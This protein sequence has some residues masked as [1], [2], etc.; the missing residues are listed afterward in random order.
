[1]AKRM[2]IF[3]V[4]I[5]FLAGLV[6]A[7]T[8]S[9]NSAQKTITIA[10]AESK[11][12]TEQQPDVDSLFAGALMAAEQ[13]NKVG[14]IN[15]SAVHVVPYADANDPLIAKKNAQLI[16][17]SDALAVIGHSSAETTS[18]A[19]PIY[20][21]AQMSAL[22]AS[23]M[24]KDTI[25]NFPDYFNISYTSEQQGAYLANYAIK[26]LKRN[27]T[28]IIV[29]ESD[30]SN[31]L[32]AT[33]FENTFRGLGGTV[34]LLYKN[35]QAPG[36]QLRDAELVSI[37]G[38]I[39]AAQDS[40]END[41]LLISSNPSTSAA[42]VIEL[43]NHG[44]N[45]PILGG[46]NLS[47]QTFSNQIK[48]QK[49]EDA[50]PGYFTD[51][52][53]TTRALFQDNV[54]QFS[55]QFVS[56]Y[57]D[58]F[59]VEG[60]SNS[61]AHGYD[62][63][64]TIFHAIQ[65]SLP[66]L[67]RASVAKGIHKMT[68]SNAPFYGVT[69]PLYFDHERMAGLRQPLLGMYQ[70]GYL[71]SAPI[72]FH[73]AISENIPDLDRQ[74]K[75]GHIIVMDGYYV[76][77]T[78]I[79]YTGM[80]IIE[81]SNLDQKTST[82]TADFYLWFRYLP[83]ETD[84]DFLPENYT[85]TNAES[86][87]DPKIVSS[88][89]TNDGSVYKT[90]RISGQF[91][92]EFQ[93][94]AYPFDRQDLPIQFR[95]Q[96]AE[97]SLIEYVIDRPGMPSLSGAGLSTD[98]KTGQT[99]Q[100]VDGWMTTRIEADQSI[101][102][103]SSTLGNPFNFNKA[104]AT[105][106]SIFGF[107]ILLQ[108]NSLAIVI[109]SLLPLLITLI[110][111]YI[112]FFLPVGN[113]ERL[114]VAS[115]ALLTVAFFHLSFSE[116]LPAIGYTVAME[117]FFYAGYAVSAAIVFLETW[118]MRIEKKET[119]E[120]DEIKKAKYQK[121]RHSL[122]VAGRIIYPSV[123]LSV[124]AVGMFCFLGWID[125]NPK[126]ARDVSAMGKFMPYQQSLSNVSDVSNTASTADLTRLTL[127][128][129]RPE[130]G[131]NINALLERFEANNHD[132]LITHLPSSGDS[133]DDIL[134]R[135][136]MSGKGPDLFFLRPF[137]RRNAEYALEL[138][139]LPIE[140]NFEP[141]LRSPWQDVDG[142]YFGLPYVGV[143]QGVYYNKDVFDK[144]GISAPTTWEEFLQASET[145]KKAGKTPIGNS[146]T[147]N[148]ENDMFMS[149]ATNFIGGPKGR[150]RYNINGGSCFND[151][152]AVQAFQSIKDLVP[153]LPDDFKQISSYTSKQRFINQ[154]AVMLFG[155]SWDVGYFA[156][157]AKFNWDVFA[158]P[159]PKGSTTYVIFQPDIAIGINKNISL[160]HQQAALRF[161][162]WLMTQAGIKETLSELPGFYPLV[163]SPLKVSDLHGTQ[164]QQL[165]VNH[166]ID[167][168][169]AYSE[170]AVTNQLPSAGSLMQKAQYNI[171]A[172]NFTPQHA[173]DDVQAGLAQWYE[174]AQTCKK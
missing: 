124:V 126:S 125:L 111:V 68:A 142:E 64:L 107:H 150:S 97:S 110:L 100:S 33:K 55:S 92:H 66:D 166:P 143:I 40:L 145:I 133:Y 42:I 154:Q 122:N 159:A 49:I 95:N 164:F 84:P 65:T 54:N 50:R 52:I 83:N 48:S 16:V 61:A 138:S 146:L 14:G 74:I 134:S 132:I 26:V 101:L 77:V 131:P 89:T 90:Y 174:P 108:R 139:S 67:S 158:P 70:Y 30:S 171:V 109:K 13:I 120:Q 165:T 85:F 56:D 98:S 80:D 135:T 44:F 69:G 103:T 35:K 7:C 75:K 11:P 17:A 79:I 106:F 18:I 152:N 151:V 173:A 144:L 93:F 59:N 53:L 112:T 130:D 115:G 41:A 81:L 148:E 31:V 4:L 163:T 91:K 24:G 73:S 137:D 25:K 27:K 153:Y 22:V 170:L 127:A 72:Q 78:H 172:Y 60:F 87:S 162:K 15:G 6:G 76:Y 86:T 46:D 128:S 136:L 45:R 168:R 167:L 82:Y 37:I 129:W 88:E 58:R 51:G 169:W 160:A 119:D 23:A 34:E 94:Q 43:K 47:T 161:L 99:F 118:S 96:N 20:Q 105:N 8:T 104:T 36:S 29:D 114:G 12:G 2:G 123:I 147:A 63:A 155:G 1:M 28:M 38:S 156:Q 71:I 32:L 117:Y 157:N 21:K 9:V 149:L 141:S 39:F 19:G 57:K 113:S 116:T 3:F 102:S 121:Q 62:A 10:V 5:I 140:K